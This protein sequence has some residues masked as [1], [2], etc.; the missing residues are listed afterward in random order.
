MLP[1]ISSGV[2]RVTV[3]GLSFPR[4]RS[5]L[6]STTESGGQGT[7]VGEGTSSLRSPY[8]GSKSLQPRDEPT[9]TIA[10]SRLGGHGLPGEAHAQFR[11]RNPA[12]GGRIRDTEASFAMRPP[13][14]I[15]RRPLG[16]GDTSALL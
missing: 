1:T 15:P 10:P 14:G 9:R 8:W 5:R 13:S 4:P 3:L 12:K 2:A 6:S 7:P 16:Y 11:T